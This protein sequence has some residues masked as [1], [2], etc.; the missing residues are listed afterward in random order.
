MP[1][2]HRDWAH[3]SHVCTGTGLARATSASKRYC[4]ALWCPVQPEHSR[5]SAEGEG[6]INFHVQGMLA[7]RERRMKVIQADFKKAKEK[8]LYRKNDQGPA[9]L[10]L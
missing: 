3:P 6:F 9:G 2:P 7:L 1:R 8:A 5:N 4:H 10:Y